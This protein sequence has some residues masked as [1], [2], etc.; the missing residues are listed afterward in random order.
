MIQQLR[1]QY[2]ISKLCEMLSV[3]ESGY[4]EWATRKPSRRQQEEGRLEVAIKAAHKASRGAHGPKKLQRDL[5][6]QGIKVGECRIR[7]I[8]Q[9]KWDGSI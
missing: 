2:A 1:L 8:R 9:N 5:A 3:S 4:Y 6:E 7:R